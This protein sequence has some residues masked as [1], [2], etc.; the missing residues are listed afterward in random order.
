MKNSPLQVG[1]SG[2]EALLLLLLTSSLSLCAALHM[3]D[4]HAVQMMCARSKERAN[5][6]ITKAK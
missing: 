2:L 6:L 1:V 3:K 5:Y 4:K